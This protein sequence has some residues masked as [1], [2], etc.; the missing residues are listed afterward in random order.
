MTAIFNFLEPAL[1]YIGEQCA[2]IYFRV[3]AGA[4]FVITFLRWTYNTIEHSLQ[5]LATQFLTMH[6]QGIGAL[7]QLVSGTGGSAAAKLATVEI[8]ALIN[9]FIPLEEAMAYFSALFL[10]WAVKEILKWGLKFM[11]FV[12]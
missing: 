3:A 1:N 4:I 11:P 7:D 5:N 8:A 2:K 10:L 12:G 9:T 6:S